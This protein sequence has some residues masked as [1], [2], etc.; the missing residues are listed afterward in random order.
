MDVFQCPECN[1]KFRFSS[2]LEQHLAL[3][4]PEFRAELRDE[5]SKQAREERQKKRDL[6]G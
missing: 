5:V 3:D 2:E 4:H 1:L 6:K